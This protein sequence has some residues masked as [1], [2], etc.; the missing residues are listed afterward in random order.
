M[1]IMGRLWQAGL[2]EYDAMEG[3]AWRWQSVDGAM[4]KTHR[5]CCALN[6]LAAAIMCFGKVRATQNIIYR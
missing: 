1:Q 6:M 4:M 5:S 2:A 3:I